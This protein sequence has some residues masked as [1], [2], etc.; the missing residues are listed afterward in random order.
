MKDQNLGQL[1]KQRNTATRTRDKNVVF[2][3]VSLLCKQE[4]SGALNNAV[5]EVTSSAGAR[6]AL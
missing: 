4:S 1:Q 3:A 6:L 5:N 2:V